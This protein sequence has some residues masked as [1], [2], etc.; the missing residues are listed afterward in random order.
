MSQIPESLRKLV[1]ARAGHRCEYCLVREGNFFF[2]FE[3]DHIISLKHDGDTDLEN[4]AL[5]CGN[6]N[7]HK[8]SNLGTYLDK[9]RR[10]VRLFDP[11][12]TFGQ[13][14]LNL[15]GLLFCPKRGSVERPFRF[16]K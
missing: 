8:G 4:L 6:C 10:F 13:A 12:E 7:R 2:S 5:A 15:T 9:Q 1:A 11:R 14:T 16:W 3:V